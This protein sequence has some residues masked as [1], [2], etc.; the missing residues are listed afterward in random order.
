MTPFNIYRQ[1]RTE[2]PNCNSVNV[3]PQPYDQN[4]DVITQEFDCEE[5]GLEWYET[6]ILASY[7][8]TKQPTLDRL[9]KYKQGALNSVIDR[10]VW[11]ITPNIALRDDNNGEYT[12]LGH[13]M[14]DSG[15]VNV[16]IALTATLTEC[17]ELIAECEAIN[18]Q[19]GATFSNVDDLCVMNA[20]HVMAPTGQ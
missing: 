10:S 5:C 16:E 1:N 2:C 12:L 8:V 14:T 4:D 3:S 19:C 9:T 18:W 7:S 11:H 13:H 15:G 6:F 17:V 20:S